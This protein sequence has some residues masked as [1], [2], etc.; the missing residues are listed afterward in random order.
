MLLCSADCKYMSAAKR[1]K[2][3]EEALK[4]ELEASTMSD[5]RSTDDRRGSDP[6]WGPRNT[7]NAFQSSKAHPIE[8][9]VRDRDRDKDRDRGRDRSRSPR[10]DKYDQYI[11]PK[12]KSTGELDQEREER[13]RESLAYIQG[14]SR[15]PLRDLIP[16]RT[17]VSTFTPQV[18]SP[19]NDSRRKIY[20]YILSY[21]TPLIPLPA[22]DHLI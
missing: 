15:S 8:Q 22:H 3:R 2:R 21:I 14:R 16:L 12:Y 18:P 19:L 6:P 5:Y 17:S 11:P 4:R 1:R 13:Y 20:Y 9:R 10:G 7:G